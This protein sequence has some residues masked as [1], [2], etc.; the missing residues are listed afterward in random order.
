MRPRKLHVA[1]ALII[2]AWLASLGWLVRREYFGRAPGEVAASA[3]VAPGAV[4]YAVYLNGLQVGTGATTV[5][6]MADGVRISERADVALPGADGARSIRIAREVRLAPSLALVSFEQAVSGDAPATSVSA[7][8]SGGDSVAVTLSW[9]GRGDV[10]RNVPAGAIPLA[11]LPVRVVSE[12]PIESGREVRI[13][14]IDPLSGAVRD[15]GFVIGDRVTFVV[16][17]SAQLDS[18]RR[19]WVPASL[20][21]VTAWELS[22]TGSPV[23]ARLWIDPQGFV[24]RA[25]T[26]EGWTILRTA[27]E[28]AQLNLRMGRPHRIPTPPLGAAFGPRP[29][30]PSPS[31]TAPAPLVPSDAAAIDSAAARLAADSLPPDARARAL[32]EF[33]ARRVAPGDGP[34]DALAALATR[35]GSE[36]SRALLLTALARSAGIP[37]RAMSG[38]RF[39]EGRWMPDHWVLLHLGD[40][41][42]VDPVRRA[43][44]AEP[45]RY[46]LRY[47]AG[48]HPLEYLAPAAR[49]TRPRA[50]PDTS[51]RSP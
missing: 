50:N 9:P 51:G 2:A 12:G 36:A 35:R 14:L 7:R 42:A 19:I 26:P 30:A 41:T 49:L 4:F 31:D 29:A 16:P 43:W 11:A 24:V 18:N 6:T 20:D 3:R 45:G 8:G 1:G 28:I 23:N 38:A 15:A 27:F 48:G 34:P 10:T 22:E 39:A 33:V 44:P 13:P 46:G 5:D 17:D 40:W 21:T 37:A 25:E 47:D 32:F